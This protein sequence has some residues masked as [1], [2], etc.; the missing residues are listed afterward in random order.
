MPSSISALKINLSAASKIC[1]TKLPRRSRYRSPSDIGYAQQSGMSQVLPDQPYHSIL[2]QTHSLASLN[3]TIRIHE[4]DDQTDA[5]DRDQILM[6]V[7]SLKVMPTETVTFLPQLSSLDIRMY[8]HRTPCYL[9]CFGP[10]G[11]FGQ[12]A[13]ERKWKV[14]SGKAPSGTLVS[15]R[16]VRPFIQLERTSSCLSEYRESSAKRRSG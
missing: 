4:Y 3:L 11:S 10:V 12:D 8:S 16:L 9:E 5:N 7:N 13:L 2:S 1:G 14:R 15:E 6:L